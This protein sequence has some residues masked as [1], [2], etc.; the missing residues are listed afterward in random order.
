[1]KKEMKE[2]FKLVF[3]WVF[4]FTVIIFIISLRLKAASPP[5]NYFPIVS[6]VNGHITQR[7]VDYINQYI[8]TQNNYVLAYYFKSQGS[9]ADSQKHYYYILTFPKT[10]SGM[11][12]GE[13]LNTNYKFN[14]YSQGTFSSCHLYEYRIQVSN[15]SYSERYDL[16]TNN[17]TNCLSYFQNK[18]SSM[19]NHNLDY[20][21][22]FNVFSS[23]N[24]QNRYL[25]LIK[26]G[27]IPI[28]D[29]DLIP[30]GAEK[31]DWENY[32]IDW[33]TGRPTFDGSSVE[34]AVQSVFSF[35]SWYASKI[36]D[37]IQNSINFV[38][39]SLNYAIQTFMNSVRAK[40]DMIK[41]TVNDFADMVEDYI[42]NIT[43]TI[44]DI[45]D[46]IS[47]FVDDFVEFADLFIHPFD[48]EEFE[49]QIEDCQLIQQ[50]NELLDNCETIQAIF[51]YAAE[52][53]TF[54]LYIDFENPFADSEHKIIHSQISF[55]WLVP[56]RSVYRPFLWVFTLIECFVGGMR[57]LGNII[58]GK[59]K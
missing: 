48:E 3:L 57:I 17:M 42:D 52:R 21:S 12:Y 27:Q 34:S 53:D 45:K 59:A 4:A 18:E 7:D 10:S 55:D 25:I 58:G 8:D 22:N 47:D 49:E 35:F 1:M 23:N 36:G 19:Y 46:K 33:S 16:V 56:L 41:D 9:A 50:Y 29:G 31:P 11:I 6:N 39:D 5:S 43:G 44:S 51:D 15:H 20:A 37:T 40:F 26:N 54:S 14:I 13:V 32:K 38:V 28:P 2:K 30:E 24:T